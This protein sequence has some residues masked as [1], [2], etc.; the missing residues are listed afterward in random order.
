MA[1]SFAQLGSKLMFSL[2][3]DHYERVEQ[4]QS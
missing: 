4:H 1:L 2:L 3:K